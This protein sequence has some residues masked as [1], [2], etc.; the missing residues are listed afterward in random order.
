MV[1][2]YYS[3]DFVLGVELQCSTIVLTVCVHREGKGRG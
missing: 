1:I 3:A 2:L